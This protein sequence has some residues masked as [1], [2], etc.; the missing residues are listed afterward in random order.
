MQNVDLLNSQLPA[1]YKS[2]QAKELGN[3]SKADIKLDR[4]ICRSDAP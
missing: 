3:C 1:L 4:R 2:F